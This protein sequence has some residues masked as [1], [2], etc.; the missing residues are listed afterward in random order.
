MAAFKRVHTLEL[1]YKRLTELEKTFEDLCN[2]FLG[3]EKDENCSKEDM[4]SEKMQELLSDA[5]EA[6]FAQ[7]SS[8]EWYKLKA[9]KEDLKRWKMLGF[10]CRKAKSSHNKNHNEDESENEKINLFFTV[11]RIS[12]YLKELQENEASE[13]NEE[14]FVKILLVIRILK[15]FLQLQLNQLPLFFNEIKVLVISNLK[16]FKESISINEDE[17]NELIEELNK[18]DEIISKRKNRLEEIEEELTEISKE[19]T[20]SIDSWKEQ[21]QKEIEKWKE[22]FDKEGDA[23]DFSDIIRSTSD[24]LKRI[25]EDCFNVMKK[26]RDVGNDKLKEFINSS[27]DGINYPLNSFHFEFVLRALKFSNLSSI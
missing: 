18:Y 7:L 13:E 26:I 23:E 22:A 20:D 27:I 24:L 19:I 5:L 3:E 16:S 17:N 21:H 2:K 14:I 1:A 25:Y 10:V 11:K 9:K 12:K 8:E 6:Y 4:D 15:I